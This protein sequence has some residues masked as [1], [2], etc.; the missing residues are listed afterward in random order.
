MLAAGAQVDTAD[1]QGYTPLMWAAIQED[2][3]IVQE[4]LARG[5]NVKAK[6]K[7]GFTV[8][9]MAGGKKV[10]EVLTHARGA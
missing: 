7:K 2:V 4:L 5:A 9:D 1:A 10:R 8:L 3:E 6:D